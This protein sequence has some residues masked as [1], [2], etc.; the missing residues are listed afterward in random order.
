MSLSSACMLTS[1]PLP[2]RAA[3]CNGTGSRRVI[4]MAPESSVRKPPL[5]GIGLPSVV[6]TPMMERRWP[7]AVSLSI[8]ALASSDMPSVITS[9]S[10]RLTP[11]CCSSSAASS[12]AEAAL[13]PCA[14]IS[15]G[16]SEGTRF[17][18]VLS[19]SVRGVTVNAVAAYTT[20]AVCPP[21]RALTRSS[22][23]SRALSRREGLTSVACIDC[24]RSSAITSAD[25]SRNTGCGS[26]FQT[27]PAMAMMLSAV[28]STIS[29][30]GSRLDFLPP[31]VRM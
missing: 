24:E 29:S 13:L 16:S 19:S 30:I 3:R 21:F 26:C 4:T 28:A 22:T 8:A 18:I 27:G 6:P 10:P 15:A 12:S 17:A 31:A 9:T 23:F 11:A 14:G 5:N 7:S 1:T 20:R 25:A 2:R